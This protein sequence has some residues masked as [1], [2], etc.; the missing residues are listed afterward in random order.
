M[1][2]TRKN[3]A[4]ADTVVR[5]LTGGRLSLAG[6]A[7]ISG[8]SRQT[9]S[10]WLDNPDRARAVRLLCAGAMQEIYPND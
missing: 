8:V 2:K 10:N 9:L 4:A 1:S 6:L 5:K 7:A 3:Q